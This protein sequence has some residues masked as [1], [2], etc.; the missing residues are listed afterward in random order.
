MNKRLISMVLAVVLL[1]AQ[2][3]YADD[4]EHFFRFEEYTEDGYYSIS[5]TQ[6]AFRQ[7]FRE[8]CIHCG[9]LVKAYYE[10]PA[11]LHTFQRSGYSWHVEGEN[12]HYY[13]IACEGC[14]HAKYE[15]VACPGTNCIKNSAM[16]R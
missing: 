11:D 9:L 13:Q 15:T 1:F 16:T 3:A 5:D 6:H 14:G 2:H 8:V 10:F 7:Y 4:C 12:V